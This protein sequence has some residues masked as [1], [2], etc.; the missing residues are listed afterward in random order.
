[1]KT[2][3]VLITLATASLALADTVSYQVKGMHCGA[4]QKAIEAKVCKMEGV[5]SCKVELTNPKKKMGQITL[6]TAQGKP[7]DAVEVEKMVSSAGDYHL[8]R[9]PK[10]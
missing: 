8:I 9:T 1:M 2:I 3:L 6:T 4:C 7:V 5:Q 10:K